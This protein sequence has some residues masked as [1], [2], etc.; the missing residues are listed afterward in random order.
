MLGKNKNLKEYKK[1]VISFI[2]FVFVE[3]VTIIDLQ[4]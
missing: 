1:H 2:L 4:T 3:G